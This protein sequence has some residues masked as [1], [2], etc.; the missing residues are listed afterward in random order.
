MG[1][2]QMFTLSVATNYIAGS[3]EARFPELPHSYGMNSVPS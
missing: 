1:R 2:Q 3:P